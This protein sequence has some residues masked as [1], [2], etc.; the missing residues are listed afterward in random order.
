[1]QQSAEEKNDNVKI[2]RWNRLQRGKK[3]LTYVGRGKKDERENRKCGPEIAR[4][5]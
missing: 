4:E 1:M 3:F 5:F 2:E